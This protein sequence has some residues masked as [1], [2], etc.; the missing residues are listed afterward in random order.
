MNK[1]KY[2]PLI[3]A[4]LCASGTAVSG[5]MGP[6]ACTSVLCAMDSP[7]G[8]YA[9]G[10]GYYVKPSETG[11]GMVTDSWLYNVGVNSLGIPETT[12]ISKPFNPDSKWAGSATLGYDVPM[13]ANNIEGSYLY[14]NNRSHARHTFEE[15][16]SI[17]FGSVLFPD[18]TVSPTPNFVSNAYLRYKLD[19]ADLKVGRKYTDVNHNFFLHPSIGVR[20]ASLQHSLIFAAPGNVISKFR[21][22]GPLFSIEGNYGLAYGFGLVGYLDYALL[23]G[24]SKAHSYVVLG[25]NSFSFKW[26]K[27]DRITSSATLRIGADYKV[28]S[29]PMFSDFKIEAG[30]QVNQYINSLDTIRGTIAFGGIQRINGLETNSF[31]FRGPYVSVAVHA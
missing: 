1:N 26:P 20:Y 21:G 29:M 19:Q 27:R 14:L 3:L 18:A 4:G 15:D 12:A 8:F 2:L 9:S 16:N 24:Q 7:G 23:A 25:S 31:G 6:V 10:T 22:A 11:I 17:G 5:T 13:T 30:Y 28:K